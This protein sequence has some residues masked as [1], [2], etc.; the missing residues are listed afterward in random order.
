[1]KQRKKIF[2][3]KA[4]LLAVSIL[5]LTGCGERMT[6]ESRVRRRKG[7]PGRIRMRI[8]QKR[9]ATNR[10]RARKWTL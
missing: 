1:M 3:A 5:V 9:K 4:V 7:T 10:N 2:A 8:L 6:A